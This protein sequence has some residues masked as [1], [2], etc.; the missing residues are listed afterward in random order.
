MWF[1][2]ERISRWP[3][4]WVFGYYAVAFGVSVFVIGL[5][6][7]GGGPGWAVLAGLLFATPMTLVTWRQQKRASS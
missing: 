5:F 4:H 3:L 2:R 1:M 7:E 6:F